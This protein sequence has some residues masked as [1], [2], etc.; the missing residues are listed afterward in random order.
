MKK[1]TKV[2]QAKLDKGNQ[3]HT[4]HTTLLRGISSNST[5]YRT[6]HL[7]QEK[8]SHWAVRTVF[9]P[10]PLG[11][12][13]EWIKEPFVYYIISESTLFSKNICFVCFILF[14]FAKISPVK[15]QPQIIGDSEWHPLTSQV[16]NAQ[17][18]LILNAQGSHLIQRTDPKPPTL[19]LNL[20]QTQFK[21]ILF[22]VPHFQ[23]ALALDLLVLVGILGISGNVF[24]NFW[25]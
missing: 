17:Y 8:D 15:S 6:S 25:A 7:S 12:L 23:Q 21:I 20:P 19:D 5:M 16:N 10:F 18:T 22:K 14:Q 9:I 3:E 4:G 24:I 2:V 1:K 13:P 11:K